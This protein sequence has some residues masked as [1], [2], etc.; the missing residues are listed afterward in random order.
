VALGDSVAPAGDGP[1]IRGDATARGERA[2]AAR[3]ALEAVALPVGNLNDALPHL[4]RPFAPEAVKFKVQTA[5]GN[6]TP[7]GCVI[8]SYIDARLVVERLNAVCGGEWSAVYRPTSKDDLMLCDLTVFGVTRTDLGEAKGKGLSKDLIS[9]AL[10]RSAVMF[11]IGVSVYALPQVTWYLGPERAGQI[12]PKKIGNKDSVA[13]EDL[14]HGRLRGSY[15]QW[16]ETVGVEAFG[17]VL[18]HGD[19]VPETID[20]DAEAALD[21]E[22]F[23][24][25][26]P[27]ALEDEKA[28]ALQ[29]EARA[30]YKEISA[31]QGAKRV[32]PPAT[33]DA[34]LRQSAHSHEALARLVE[35][36]RSR[37][38][39]LVGGD[40]S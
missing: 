3:A 37:R 13:L 31:V 20:P 21:G 22:E 32:F 14:G 24:P 6:P 19:V 9:D 12:K 4:R 29:D 38:D 27:A 39:E 16:L 28:V 25:P 30:L 8:V 34:W 18:D 33:F 17:P 10:K 40:G 7:T 2:A 36:V 1:D 23:V 35:H 15:G 11:G 26:A 5:F